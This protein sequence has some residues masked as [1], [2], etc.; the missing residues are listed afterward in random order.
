M[1]AHDRHITLAAQ[2]IRQAQK[3]TRLLDNLDTQKFAKRLVVFMPREPKSMRSSRAC[4]RISALQATT[5]SGE[6]FLTTPIAS[7]R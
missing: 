3:T 2:P 1:T 6:L 7:G 4:K 5:S